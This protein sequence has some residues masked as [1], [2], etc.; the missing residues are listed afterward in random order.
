MTKQQQVLEYMRCKGDPIYFITHYVY[1]ELPGGDLLFNLYGK[2]REYIKTILE[3]NHVICLKS[4]QTGVSTTT[5]AYCAWL[6]LFH[7]NVNIGVISKDGREA[8]RFATIVKGMVDKVPDWMKPPKGA[9]GPGFKVA[10]V[11]QFVLTNGSSMRSAVVDPKAPNKSLRG[12]PIGLL[13]LDECAHIGRLQA[14]WESLVPTL[15]T[16]QKHA[17]S[18]GIPYGTILISTPNK[19]CGDGLF[20]YN[21]YMESTS[22]EFCKKEDMPEGTFKN[23]TVYWRD[24]PELADDPHWF[25]QQ[26]VLFSGDEKRI[27]QELE[28]QFVPTEGTFFDTKTCSIIQKNTKDIVPEHVY[29]LFNGECWEFAKPILNRHYIIGVDVASEYGNDKSTIT[30]WDYVTLDQVWEYQGKLP[31]T[32]FC[33]VV[34]YACATYPGTVVPEANSMGNQVAEYIDRTPYSVMLYKYWRSENNVIRGISTDIKTR[35]LMMNALYSYVSQYPQMIKSKRLALELI[36]L[37]MKN[38]GKV[39]ADEGGFDDLAM[40]LAFCCYVRMHDPPLGVDMHSLQE[41]MFRDI[42]NMN[43]ADK[44]SNVFNELEDVDESHQLDAANARLMKY[45]KEEMTDYTNNFFDTFKY[46]RG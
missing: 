15:A 17:R 6:L 36:G 28:L 27:A 37:T 44:H 35:P 13:I 3:F 34:E 20:F 11:Q 8:S 9:A 30:I 45:A 18:Q 16:A 32:D 29:K 4:R 14:A 23:F 21:R 26:K 39:E 41:S 10:N 38:S 25:E 22:Y 46:T 31:V 40:S 7:D 24:I 2:Q 1:I 33:K 12:S 19:A 5:Q 42:L 43:Y